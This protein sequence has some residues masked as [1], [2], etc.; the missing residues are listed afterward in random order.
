M[1][2][3]VLKDSPF[4][5]F[6]KEDH[7]HPGTKNVVKGVGAQALGPDSSTCDCCQWQN[8]DCS[9][10]TEAAACRPDSTCSRLVS[11]VSLPPSVHCTDAKCNCAA[12][13]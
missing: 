9:D 2:T 7:G 5:A 10:G 3:C 11:V 8:R 13:Y 12:L 1:F 4:Q 6:Q